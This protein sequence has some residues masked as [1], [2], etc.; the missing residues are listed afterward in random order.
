MHLFVDSVQ[1][2]FPGSCLQSFFF[3]L[4]W[5]LFLDSLE[6]ASWSSNSWMHGP[7]FLRVSVFRCSVTFLFT[8]SFQCLCLFLVPLIPFSCLPL[9]LQNER[10]TWMDQLKEKKGRQWL[11]TYCTWVQYLKHEWMNEKKL[12]GNIIQYK[13]GKRQQGNSVLIFLSRSQT[14]SEW[15]D[16]TIDSSSSCFG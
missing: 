15:L 3:F 11:W 14:R 2:S 13:T 9:I 12:T 1:W 5:F 6:F 4:F 8:S 10:G 7:G 16:F